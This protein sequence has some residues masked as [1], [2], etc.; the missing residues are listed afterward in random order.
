MSKEKLRSINEL[1]V[2]GVDPDYRMAGREH[3]VGRLMI[4]PIEMDDN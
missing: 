2:A 1:A 4:D 3:E